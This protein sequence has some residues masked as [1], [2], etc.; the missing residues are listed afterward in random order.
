M[1]A[2]AAGVVAGWM[3]DRVFGDPAKGHPVAAFGRVA[4]WLERRFWRPNRLVGV[5]YAAVLV[6]G[7]TAPVVWTNRRLRNRPAARAVLLTAAV[8]ASLGGKSL[9]RCA[10]NLADAVVRGDLEGGRRRAPALVGRDTSSL[11]A[12]ELCRAAVESVAENTADAVAGPLVWAAV[13]GA[14]GAVAYRAVNTLDAMVGHRSERY[15]LFGW[16][17]ARLDDVATWAPAR[18]AAALAVLLAPLVRGDRGAAWRALRR[19]GADHPSPNAGRLEAAFAG[20][21]GV[22]LGGAN[23]YGDRLQVRPFLGHGDMPAPQDVLRA[24]QLADAVGLFTMVLAASFAWWW[25]P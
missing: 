20:A 22:R 2:I 9:N 14:G 1:A 3:S 10:R 13:G 12:R 17:A 18:L 23:R 25:R 8:W 16:A 15:E 19:N 24:V 5:L 21:L 7:V 4:S 11:D 6:A